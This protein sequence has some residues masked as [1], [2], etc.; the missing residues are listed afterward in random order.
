MARKELQVSHLLTTLADSTGELNFAIDNGTIIK[1]KLTATVKITVPLWTQVDIRQTSKKEYLIEAF[2][3]MH[4]RYHPDLWD[5]HMQ[6][7][8]DWEQI[9]EN[10]FKR[11]INSKWYLLKFDRRDYVTLEELS[12][13]EGS[14]LADESQYEVRSKKRGK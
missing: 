14:R 3:I 2:Q 8:D 5:G 4:D 1:G 11:D 12:K 9:I 10:S 13:H 7:A 6:A